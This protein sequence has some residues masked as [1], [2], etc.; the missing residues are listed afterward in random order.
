MKFPIRLFTAAMALALGLAPCLRAMPDTEAVAGRLIV[1]KYADTVVTVRAQILLKVTVGERVTPVNDQKVDQCGTLITAGGLTITSLTGLDPR[2]IFEATRPQMNTGGMPVELGQTEVKNLRL[3]LGDGTEI[4]AKIVWK[5]SALDV[6]LVAPA[7]DAPT[8]ARTF[9]CADIVQSQ[10][11]A[12][13]MGTY[14]HL[15]RASEAMQRIPVVRPS[16]ITGILERPR[17]LFMVSTDQLPDGTGG[18]IFDTDG[19]LL[20][21]CLRFILKGLPSG[22]AVLPTSDILDVA[23]RATEGQAQ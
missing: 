11:P 14:F 16:T 23:T 20:G 13:L 21:V 5:D 12:V 8:A 3:R 10:A 2:A 15:S 22:A 4:P 19:R 6:A 9:A 17:H 7:D 18:P 1:R